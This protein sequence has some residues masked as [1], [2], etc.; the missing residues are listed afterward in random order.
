MTERNG[1]AGDNDDGQDDDQQGQ[2]DQQQGGGQDGRSQQQGGKRQDRTDKDSGPSA[3]DLQR[4][5]DE[6]TAERDKWKTQSRRH[7][8]Q[9]KQNATDAKAKQTV[10][11]QLAALQEQLSARDAADVADKA[12]LAG[13]RLQAKLVRGGLSDDDATTLVGTIDVY[14]LLEEGKPDQG[15]IDKTA[16]SLLKVGTRQTPDRDQGRKGGD[17]APS[18]SELIR[19][20]ARR[21]HVGG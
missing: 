12:E 1:Q 11:E 4:Q 15:A 21:N 8:S 16:K 10:E 20:A 7:E 13:E 6:L 17:A 19:G 9:A 5:I 3:D 18:M 2:Q 14:R